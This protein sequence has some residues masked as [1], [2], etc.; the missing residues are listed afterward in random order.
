[1]SLKSIEDRLLRLLDVS[2]T[3]IDLAY[4][5]LLYNDEAIAEEVLKLEEEVDDLHTDFELEVLKLRGSGDEKGILGLVRLG[6]S[7]EAISDAAA[8]IADLI[9]RDIQPHPIL[10]LVFHETEETVSLIQVGENSMLEGKSIGE[11]E[12]EEMGINILAVK[13]LGGHWLRSPPKDF[14]LHE[15]DMIVV[16]GY[17]DSVKELSNMA[18]KNSSKS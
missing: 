17:R 9:V 18:S 11:L 15:G 8:S 2:R 16:S 4:Y 1:M 13:K 10:H 3:M 14:I 6:L 5:A 12:F 7:A